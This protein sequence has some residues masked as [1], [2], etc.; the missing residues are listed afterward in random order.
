MCGI[1]AYVSK[2]RGVDGSPARLETVEQGTEA[3]RHRGPDFAQTRSFGQSLL[4]H[5]RLA[6]VDP[7]SGS[8]PIVDGDGA[9]AVNGE[10]YNHE[11]MRSRAL[12]DYDFRSSCDCEVIPPA[13]ARWGT[14]APSSLDGVFAFVWVSLDGTRFVAARDP[15]GV[16]PLYFAE[17]ADGWWFASE[18]KALPD[19]PLRAF[20]PG[21]ALS[22]TGEMR[23]YH[24]EA[25]WGVPALAPAP[26]YAVA[27]SELREA[28][29][30]AVRK[31]MMA[32]VEFGV[33]LSGGLDSSLIAAIAQHPPR[34]RWCH[35]E[36]HVSG[37]L[38]SL[39]ATS[40]PSRSAS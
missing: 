27:A 19:V 5:T 3:L 7:S 32:D 38:S 23:R 35:V 13:C 8:Q 10:I 16:N 18:R 22:E 9:A 21:H 36:H 15:V 33:L 6:I 40:P 14:T 28:L 30:G 25:P 29:E 1:I 17:T 11:E 12:S 31:R 20:P 4:G 26:S 34:R 24:T 2:G 37:P 39:R